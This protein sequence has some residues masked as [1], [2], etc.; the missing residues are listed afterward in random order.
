M[1]ELFN[2]DFQMETHLQSQ[3]NEP[4]ISFSDE[5]LCLLLVGKQLSL[6]ERPDWQKMLPIMSLCEGKRINHTNML[7]VIITFTIVM[8]LM[9]SKKLH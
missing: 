6:N 8:V 5:C 7:S 9:I 2:A 1:T 3:G 4:L